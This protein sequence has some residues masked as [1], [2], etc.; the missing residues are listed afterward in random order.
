ML[1]ESETPGVTTLAA[2][3]RKTA[4]TSSDCPFGVRVRK[5]AG[6]RSDCMFGARVRNT[7]S[8]YVCCQSQKHQE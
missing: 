8:D 5:T 3:V 7:R 4:S 2:R 6:T 1:P